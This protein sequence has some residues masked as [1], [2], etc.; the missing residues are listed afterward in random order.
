MIKYHLLLPFITISK[1]IM[2]REMIMQWNNRMFTRARVKSRKTRE[3]EIELEFR[4]L[5]LTEYSI[6][7]FHEN[8]VFI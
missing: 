8:I 6:E 7:I 5:G 4:I 1:M 3:F 2:T